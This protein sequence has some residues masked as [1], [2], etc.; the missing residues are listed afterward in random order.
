MPRFRGHLSAINPITAMMGILHIYDIASSDFS[1]RI[2]IVRI[3]PNRLLLEKIFAL[4]S[5]PHRERSRDEHRRRHIEESSEPAGTDDTK[6]RESEP[7][8]Q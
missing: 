3:M 6:H 7:A 1:P 5:E 4:D 2:G 8:E